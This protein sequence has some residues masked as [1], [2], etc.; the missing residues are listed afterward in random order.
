MGFAFDAF[1]YDAD[2]GAPVL[3]AALGFRLFLFQVPYACVVVIA[4]G[5]VADLTDTQPSS[6][7]HGR[8]VAALMAESVS[9]AAHFSGWARASACAVALYALFL[10]SR[11]LVKVLNI[12]H[13]LV[14]DVPRAR[15]S[16]PN[17]AAV[18]YI[19]VITLLLAASLAIAALR[20][21]NA[22]GGLILLMLFTLGPFAFWF[23][24]SA[25]FPH[26]RC[27][28]I[29]LVPG[30]MLFAF[31]VELLHV[32]TVVWFPHYVASKSQ[33]YGSIGVAIVLLLWAYFVGRI[34]TLAVV[35]NAA[36]WTRFGAGSAH[37]VV[38]RRP[39]W[40]V[41][42]VDDKVGR[43]WAALFTDGAPEP[44]SD[45]TNDPNR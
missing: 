34:V 36:L 18:V 8:G 43:A 30:A 45:R 27:P 10:A 42:L 35:L 5:F 20:A 15:V 33:V 40:R 16:R 13:T 25:W 37:P 4:S 28:L 23:L 11:S 12:V 3:A 44:A 38:F 14:W 26:R 41:P 2:T 24:A 6:L 9:D 1:S 7:F 31:G 29:A 19:G 32:V 21:R 17:R 39:S 22:I